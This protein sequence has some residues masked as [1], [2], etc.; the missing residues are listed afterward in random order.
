MEMPG[1]E[2][3]SPG[4]EAFRNEMVSSVFGRVEFVVPVRLP[5]AGDQQANG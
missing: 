1:D 5:N 2:L 3:W 4:E